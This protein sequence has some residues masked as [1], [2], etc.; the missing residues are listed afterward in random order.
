[1]SLI[2]ADKMD[3]HQEVEVREIEESEVSL[4]LLEMGI[5]PGKRLILLHIAPLGDP[6]A[7]QV[8]DAVI[9]LRKDEAQ[10]VKVETI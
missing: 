6:M 2:S 7:F 8:D 10:F 3:V 4:K 5:L 1:M 9:A